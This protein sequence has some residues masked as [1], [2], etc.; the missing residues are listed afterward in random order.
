MG[1]AF[2]DIYSFLHF[3]TGVIFR[4]VG[5]SW[6]IQL[7]AHIIFEII[8]NTEFGMNIINNYLFFWPGKKPSADSYL[9]SVGDVS[10][11]VVGWYVA[12][13]IINSTNQ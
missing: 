1:V 3:G 12:D 7:L 5:L 4:L 6:E 2:L 8:E 9:N 11:G 13:L 10:C